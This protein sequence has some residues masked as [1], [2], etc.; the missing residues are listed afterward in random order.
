MSIFSAAEQEQIIHAITLAENK[1]SGE[2]RIAVEQRCRTNALDRAAAYFK[3]L[4]MHRTTLRN[5]VLVYIAV[6]DRVFAI[7]GDQGI[8]K[9]VAPDFWDE[10]KSLMA[11]FFEKGDLVAGLV[12]GIIHTGK[13][14]K[15]YFP[16]ADDDVNEL[17][18]DIVFGKH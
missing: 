13:Q 17:P 8:H 5:G 18:D 3:K 16:V 1:T 12:A 10:T 14:L 4:G 11:E 9:V 15:Q 6:E 7:I 2:I